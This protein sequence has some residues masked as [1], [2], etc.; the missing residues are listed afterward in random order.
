MNGL[1]ECLAGFFVLLNCLQLYRDK[2]VKGVSIVA[3]LFFTTWGYW[4]LYYYPHLDQWVSFFGGLSIV[5]VNT[6]WVG[7]MVYYLNR[8]NPRTTR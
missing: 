1:Y 6:L 5:T 3:T 4:N 7:M 2:A 8:A